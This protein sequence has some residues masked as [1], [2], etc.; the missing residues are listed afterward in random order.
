[1][2]IREIRSRW[3]VEDVREVTGERIEA[4]IVFALD[5]LYGPDQ[6]KPSEETSRWS[7]AIRSP[8]SLFNTCEIVV[9]IASE[10]ESSAVVR[11][12]VWFDASDRRVDVYTAL[13][14]S[15]VGLP[16]AFAWREVSVHRARA[17]A[18]ATTGRF[19]EVLTA[20]ATSSAYR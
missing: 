14:M 15:V 10:A 7:C 13:G 11:V 8:L 12:E 16:V 5:A 1:V 4:A 3:S 2:A 18:A 17:F 9:S 6:A 19:F 20:R